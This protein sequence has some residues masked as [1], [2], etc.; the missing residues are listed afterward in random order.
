MN[1]SLHFL[2]FHWVWYLRQLLVLLNRDGHHIFC[3]AL[4]A[5]DKAIF[6]QL[7]VILFDLYFHP[8]PRHKM[9]FILS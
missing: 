7:H 5:Y 4:F 2:V 9:L 3:A 6:V 1:L 8:L